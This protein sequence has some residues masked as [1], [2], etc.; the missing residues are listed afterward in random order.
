MIDYNGNKPSVVLHRTH[1]TQKQDVEGLCYNKKNNRLLLGIKGKDQNSNDYKGIYAFDLSSKKL[2]VSPVYKVDLTHNIWNEAEGENKV[3]PA[4]LGV[5]P[6]SGDIYLIDN[7]GPRLLVMGA[8]GTKKNVY[9][10]SSSEF[11]QP[12]GIAFT[13]EGEIFISNEGKSGPGTILKVSID[14][15]QNL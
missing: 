1:L 9:Q 15:S 12:E 11:P 14:K 8:D 13:P 10:L 7:V 6:I 4:D 3:E 5:H 2:S